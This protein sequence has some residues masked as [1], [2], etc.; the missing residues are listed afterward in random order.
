LGAAALLELHQRS[1]LDEVELGL[2]DAEELEADEDADEEA[3]LSS[4]CESECA[5]G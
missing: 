2:P 5:S 4:E 1:Q 3:E